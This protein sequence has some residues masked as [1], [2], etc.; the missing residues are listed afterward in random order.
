MKT[1]LAAF[2][3]RYS[4]SSPAV[5]YLQKYNSRFDIDVFEFSINDSLDS[6][7]KK[8]LKS[9]ADVYCFSCYIWNIELIL[10]TAERLKLAMP[11]IKIIF[12][13]PE[14]GYNASYL[15]KRYDYIDCII[16]GE[17]EYVLGEVLETIKNGK[18]PERFVSGRCLDLNH[19]VQPYTAEDL[20][21]LKGKIIYFETSR[22]CPFN[23]SYC[24]SSAEHGVR[25]FPM[26]YVK[27]GL[28]LLMSENVPLV[29]L[30]DRTFNSNEERAIE[31]IEYIIQNSKST[32]VHF[33]IEAE[34]MSDRIIEVLNSA[35]KDLFQLE[36]GIQSINQKTLN[37]V[38]R[39]FDAE[40]TK[41]NILK[42]MEPHNMHIHLDLIAGLPYED[43]ESFTHSFDYVYSMKP[44]M[45][46]L[47]FLKVLPGTEIERFRPEIFA[48]S[49]PPYEVVATKWITAAEIT[50]LKEVEEAVELYYN[51]GR[52]SETIGVLETLDEFAASPFRLYEFLG[53]KLSEK[54]EAG[55]IKQTGLYDLL[56]EYFGDSIIF[57]LARDFLRNN[58]TSPLPYYLTRN[59]SKSFKKRYI[60][61]LTDEEFM[62]K[63][64]ISKDLKN[65]RFENIL[66]RVYVTDY[67]NKLF[68]D[69]S[70]Y[71]E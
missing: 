4:H 40:R 48:A 70:E 45:L 3:A 30:V 21:K 66:G 68:Y 14:S 38:N 13:G 17:G 49:Y 59:M 36:I 67:K 2:N 58:K 39:R 61:L 7:Y 34:I 53:R 12:G 69:I 22:G 25:Y 20:Q 71:F 29:K 63:Y 9:G 64:K 37:A 27:E 41:A 6:V 10:K 62:T 32:R 47:G 11:N 8:L 23:C 57:E 28:G 24:L 18:E 16:K 15:L 55:K 54:S 60:S 33:E 42:L 51:S 19:A 50:K 44:D 31:I 35:P 1:V 26:E 5:R 46:Q 56:Y 65:L 43:Y 52:F